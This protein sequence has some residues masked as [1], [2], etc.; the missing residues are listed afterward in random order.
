MV[1]KTRLQMFDELVERVTALED[2]SKE[3]QGLKDLIE[4]VRE[5]EEQHNE[6][7]E[8]TL[9]GLSE[10]VEE[11]EALKDSFD[12]RM[13]ELSDIVSQPKVPTGTTTGVEGGVA[14]TGSPAPPE[15]PPEKPSEKEE[16]PPEEPPEEARSE[17]IQ[18]IA[19]F[20]K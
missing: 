1:E 14:L 9:K 16:E 7:F 2:S 18:K 6:T 19:D 8:R 5:A 11:Q 13:T 15:A 12:E 10:R 3:T 4:S 20:L 17:A